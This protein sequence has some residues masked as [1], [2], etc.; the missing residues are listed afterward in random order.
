LYFRRV[1]AAG[2]G[3]QHPPESEEHAKAAAA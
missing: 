2:T 1:V 3:A